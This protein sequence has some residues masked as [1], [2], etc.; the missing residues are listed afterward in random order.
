MIRDMIA[1]KEQSCPSTSS[2]GLK[3]ATTTEESGTNEEEVF[4]S[5]QLERLQVTSSRRRRFL[6]DPGKT[7]K[8]R[9]RSLRDAPVFK[10]NVKNTSTSATTAS[11]THLLRPSKLGKVVASLSRNELQISPDQCHLVNTC[12]VHRSHK[13]KVSSLLSFSTGYYYSSSLSSLSLLDEEDATCRSFTAALYSANTTPSPPTAASLSPGA[14]EPSSYSKV[15]PQPSPPTLSN[16]S[17]MSQSLQDLQQLETISIS[18][19]MK[20]KKRAEKRRKRRLKKEILATAAATEK[21]LHA[22]DTTP[23]SSSVSSSS[24]SSSSCAQQAQKMVVVH[25]DVSVDDL[26]GYLEDSIVFPKKM[27]YMAEMMYT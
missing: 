6:R 1:T 19:E 3:T 8:D 11:A 25:H 9:S 12:K 7:A 16:F 21:E 15:S 20:S 18:E 10:K 5:G 17:A 23:S 24:S 14:G 22:P 26:A 2:D 27:S 13:P 4:L